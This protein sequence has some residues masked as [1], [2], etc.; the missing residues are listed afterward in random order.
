M[1][2]SDESLCDYTFD[3]ST[4]SASYYFQH[5]ITTICIVE[6]DSYFFQSSRNL[7]WTRKLMLEL[8][9]THVGACS[10][11]PPPLFFYTGHNSKHFV[12]NFYLSSNPKSWKDSIYHHS[13]ASDR[14]IR[15][16][17]PTTIQCT[18][19]AKNFQLRM[20][21]LN[22]NRFKSERGHSAKDLKTIF[23]ESD[24]VRLSK[25]PTETNWA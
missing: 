10:F 1:F 3:A 11:L 20:L 23:E 18:H 19:P 21:A 9:L 24:F 22:V 25:F 16:V 2:N 5:F 12:E 17:T 8:Q 15:C 13:S 4:L 6:M 14:N 7:R